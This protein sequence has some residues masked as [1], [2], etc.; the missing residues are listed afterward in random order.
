MNST[1]RYAFIAL[2]F[3]VVVVAVAA[4]WDDGDAEPVRAGDGDRA[5][6]RV[7]RVDEPA[8]PAPNRRELRHDSGRESERE[9]ALNGLDGREG[10]DVKVTT[11]AQSAEGHTVEPQGGAPLAP[12]DTDPLVGGP[13][14]APDGP[15]RPRGSRSLESTG[16]ADNFLKPRR[17][18]GAP[19]PESLSPARR[20]PNTSVPPRSEEPAPAPAA[21]DF[22]AGAEAS[23]AADL[24]EY[25]VRSGDALTVIASRECGSIKLTSEIAR[26]NG[27]S[28]VDI[29]K[30]GMTLK[31]PARASSAGAA[32]APTS[33][34]PEI[35]TARADGRPVVAISPGGTLSQLL[36]SRYGTVSGAMPLV[37]TLNPDLDPDRVQAGQPIVLPR[38]EEVAGATRPDAGNESVAASTP[39]ESSRR[40]TG[41]YVR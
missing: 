40:R 22:S 8:L 21:E 13:P 32:P 23:G 7:A 9:F 2:L 36:H 3:L 39:S 27:L 33:T 35:D 34:S 19:A 38:Y 15:M 29:I 16:A 41:N 20:T 30:E 26:L 10:D 5:D 6:R 28:D 25:V 37:K 18:T 12:L 1:D 14:P 4:F 31:L 11:R 17:S 24:R